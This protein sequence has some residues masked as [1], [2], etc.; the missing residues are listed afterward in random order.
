MKVLWF[1]NLPLSASMRAQG[2][3]P[4]YLGGWLEHLASALSASGQV[5]LCVASP[6]A[7]PHAPVREGGIE[8]FAMPIPQSRS[9]AVR[10]ARRWAHETFDHEMLGAAADIVRR[11]DA[12]LVHVHGT[13]QV[14]GL[15]GD[16][17]TDA[18]T[19]ISMQ[20][21][22]RACA[23]EY[24]TGLSSA[25]LAA[26]AVSP[27][28]LSGRGALHGYATIA[29]NARREERIIGANRYF[30]GR[31][32]WDEDFVVSVNPKAEYRR[33]GEVLRPAFRDRAKTSYEATGPLRIFSIVGGEPFKGIDT[34]AALARSLA[35]RGKQA[36]IVVAG[37]VAS[38]VWWPSLAAARRRVAPSVDIA[39]LGP[40]DAQRVSQEMSGCDVYLM[41]SHVENSSNA[42]CEAMMTGSPV[43]AARVG[44]IPSL[45]EEGVDGLL[46]RDREI[47]SCA[48]AVCSLDDDRRRARAL[49][50]AA[51]ARALERHDP[52]R[53][54]AELL[55]AYG[56]V[57]ADERP[58]GA[59]GHGG[60]AGETWRSAR[61]VRGRESDPA[62]SSEVRQ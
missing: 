16:A 47:E 46:Y 17:A 24:L 30:L 56:C 29:R 60:A 38:S 53:V 51:R 26:L 5:E 19:V 36:R 52:D 7:L 22:L 23:L 62:P 58:R 12:D 35:E 15:L 61:V 31:T 50:T 28:T 44:G 32:D 45:V 37:D 18:P 49:G 42:L 3:D 27:R 59:R 41:P 8:Y 34:I 4:W 57:L 20:G 43:V 21:V 55:E 9:A 14:F 2:L 48:D 1:T 13:E 25:R 40:V 33:V 54:V 39:V 10:W 6:T 11:V